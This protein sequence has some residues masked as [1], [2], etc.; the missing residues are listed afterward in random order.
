MEI[1]GKTA[2][3][4]FR[5]I[6]RWIQRRAAYQSRSPETETLLAGT[7]PEPETETLLDRA[8]LWTHLTSTTLANKCLSEIT[9]E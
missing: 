1:I 9:T 6:G 7:S 8:I 4:K 5:E 3:P 2:A